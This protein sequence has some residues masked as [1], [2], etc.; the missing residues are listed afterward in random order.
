MDASTPIISRTEAARQGLTH[1]FTGKPCKHGHLAK[2]S[3]KRKECMECARLRS[4]KHYR[5]DP[6]K[7]NAR[8]KAYRL[9]DTERARIQERASGSKW[10]RRNYEK[11]LAYNRAWVQANPEK[12]A[13]QLERW[14]Q[15]HQ[16]RMQNDAAYIEKQRTK[17]REKNWKRKERMA[18][19]AMA[20]H[21]EICSKKVNEICYDHCHQTG[22]FR[23][24]LCHT[25]NRVLGLAG[26]SPELLR[27]LAAYLEQH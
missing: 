5:D 17:N 9:S 4:E 8:R 1:Y 14:K 23:G 26:D 3:V 2:R 22:K 19:E 24:W 27:K 13:L 11:V 21:C 10:R 20:T 7:D 16:E 12:R 25:C 15:K 6:A 18:G